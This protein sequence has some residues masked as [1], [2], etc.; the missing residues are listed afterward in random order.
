M[1]GEFAFV[2][3]FT[4]VLKGG[5]DKVYVIHLCKKQNRHV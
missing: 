2:I 3:A 1:R 4:A 5:S